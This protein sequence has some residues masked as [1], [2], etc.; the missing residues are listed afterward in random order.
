[1]RVLMLGTGAADGWP[2]PFCRC[3]SCTRS[4]ELNHVRR[5]T[6]AVIDDVVLIDCGSE[7]AR[8]AVH[9]GRPL[10][11]LRLIL[12]THAHPDHCD[13]Q[14]LLWRSWSGTTEP[15]TIAGPA[16]ALERCRPWIGPDD[17]ITLIE[18]CADDRIEVAGYRV[19]AVGAT[20]TPGALL[21]VIEAPTGGSLLYATDTGPLSERTLQALEGA[22]L[23]AAMLE[24]TWGTVIDH[25]T[26]HLDDN[27]FPDALRRLRSID[28]ITPGTDVIAIHLGHRNP[29]EPQL[30]R[31]LDAWGARSVLDHDEIVVAEPLITHPPSRTVRA[32]RRTLVL[33]GARSGKSFEAE[34]L[35]AADVDVHYVATSTVPTLADQEWQERVARHQARR[36]D[37]WN[38]VES[39]DLTR[40]L[41]EAPEGST[42]LVDCLTLWLTAHLDALNAWGVS[43][44]GLPG[45]VDALIDGLVLALRSTRARV[46]CV[47]NE[48]GSGIVPETAS[49]RLFRDLLG[50]VNAR[51]AAECDDVL[52]VT[53]GRV[54]RLE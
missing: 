40:L 8:S 38:T 44:V 13:P 25:G 51:V 26:D 4:A 6:A 18:L 53:A 19:R 46:V 48:V 14:A 20:H 33:G 21:Y 32:P 15:L 9:A 37:H 35:V 12:F 50:I 24:L 5:Q 27:T 17:P 3:A 16:D 43:S 10:D 28:A 47:S 41:H 39:I 22:Q 11:G 42:L 36:P 23:D 30:S 31:K 2:T 54:Q 29:P 7:A 49:G 34:R 52:L 1:M 45:G